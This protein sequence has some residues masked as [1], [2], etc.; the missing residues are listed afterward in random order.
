MVIKDADY[1]LA[2]YGLK[3]IT[4]VDQDHTTHNG[5]EMRAEVWNLCKRLVV[6]PPNEPLPEVHKKVKGFAWCC[7]FKKVVKYSGSA[8]TLADHVHSKSLQN[9]PLLSHV[10]R[11]VGTIKGVTAS[12]ERIL[13]HNWLERYLM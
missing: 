13:Q 1:Y 12:A 6:H 3:A 10:W 9:R 2:Q 5:Q 11:R 7:V 4:L 8:S